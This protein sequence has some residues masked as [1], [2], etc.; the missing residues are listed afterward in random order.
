MCSKKLI[1]GSHSNNSTPPTP[2]VAQSAPMGGDN[3]TQMNTQGETNTS[4]K[5]KKRLIINKTSGV[6]TGVNL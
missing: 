1:G 2:A 5:G 6:G 4:A 3:V